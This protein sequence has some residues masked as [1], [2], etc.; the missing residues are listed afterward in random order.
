MKYRYLLGFAL[1]CPLASPQF[2]PESDADLHPKEGL[3]LPDG[4]D[5][6]NEMLKAD[7]KKSIEDAAALLK[8]VEDFKA[9][10]EK[11]EKYVLSLN[12]LKKLDEIEKLTKRIRA[13]MK[14][15]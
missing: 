12:T 4:K 11:N 2:R 10:L 1:L 14:R 15:Y 5:Q 13:R 6:R 9:E 8:T 7:Y 3:R